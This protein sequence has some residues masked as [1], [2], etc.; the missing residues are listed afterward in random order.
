[1]DLTPFI[2]YECSAITKTKD[3]YCIEQLVRGK[4]EFA[5][6][7]FQHK[8]GLPGYQCPIFTRHA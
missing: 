3:T 6:L 2:A 1:L 4:I 5:T 7:R 8:E